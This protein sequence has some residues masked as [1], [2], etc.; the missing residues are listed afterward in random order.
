MNP[1]ITRVGKPTARAIAANV[2][3]NCS[4][5]P[6]LMLKKLITASLL[7]PPC[8]V[9]EYVKLAP[10]AVDDLGARLVRSN[11]HVRE[12]GD[13]L[14]PPTP[15]SRDGRPKTSPK[16]QAE[17]VVRLIRPRRLVSV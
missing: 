13:L 17:D 16:Y 14:V 1:T 4:Q 8:T 2:P 15:P 6:F 11:P 5:Y 12:V 9:G 3:E 7:W 10:V